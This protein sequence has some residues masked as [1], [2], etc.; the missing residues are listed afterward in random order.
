MLT[1]YFSAPVMLDLIQQTPA[2]PYLD[3]LCAK[4]VA[5]GYKPTTIQRYLRAAAHVSYWQHNRTRSLTE[6]DSARIEE[7]KQHLPAC[8]CKGF[9]R[10]NDYDM[11][12]ARMF[13]QHLQETAIVPAVDRTDPIATRPPLFV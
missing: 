3:C 5:T 9:R 4:L 12:G 8:Q 1:H 7:F 6:L 13:L 11:R 10:V 2:A